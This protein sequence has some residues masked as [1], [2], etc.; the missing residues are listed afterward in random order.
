MLLSGYT[1][2]LVD[3]KQ[4]TNIAGHSCVLLLLAVVN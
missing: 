4:M 1:V 2:R 3:V